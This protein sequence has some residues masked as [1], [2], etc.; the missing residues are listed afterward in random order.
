MLLMQRT[1]VQ[2]L[3]R[4]LGSY[5]RLSVAKKKKK[6]QKTKKAEAHSSL[7]KAHQSIFLET[8]PLFPGA[9]LTLSALS[10]QWLCVGFPSLSIVT[11]NDLNK[12]CHLSFPRGTR[13]QPV[14]TD[15]ILGR[16]FRQAF[17]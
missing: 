10:H 7:F 2:S 15:I 9:S 12:S 16:K 17:L 4:V 11:F 8:P 6:T 14:C 5:K 3:V 13:L 1:Q